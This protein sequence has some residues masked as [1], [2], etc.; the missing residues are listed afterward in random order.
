MKNEKVANRKS[1]AYQISREYALLKVGAFSLILR[2]KLNLE[3]LHYSQQMNVPRPPP[4]PS[5][6]INSQKH[7]TPTLYQDPLPLIH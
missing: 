1:R 6:I 3:K 5:L 7:L 4:H 2:K